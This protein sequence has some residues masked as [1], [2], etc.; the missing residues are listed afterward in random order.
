M[1]R[2]QR[3]HH[4]PN[5]SSGVMWIMLICGVAYI[6]YKIVS[7]NQTIKSATEYERNKMNS[8]KTDSIILYDSININKDIK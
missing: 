5:V 7:C 8:E 3:Q 4:G 1:A 2:Y 6:V